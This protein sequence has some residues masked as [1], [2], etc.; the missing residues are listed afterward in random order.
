VLVSL[1]VA[2]VR[3]TLGPPCRRTLASSLVLSRPIPVLKYPL[4]RRPAYP[5]A[6][7]LADLSRRSPLIFGLALGAGCGVEQGGLGTA[8]STDTRPVEARPEAGAPAGSA[9]ALDGGQ[10][11]GSD[12]ALAAGDAALAPDAADARCPLDG[13][14]ALRIDAVVQWAG[15][16]FFDIVPIILPG[17]GDMSLT[18]LSDLRTQAGE[19]RATIRACGSEVPAFSASIGEHYGVDFADSV[20]ERVP[21]R[22]SVGVRQTCDL[23]GCAFASDVVT[24]QLGLTLAD[25]AP[26]PSPRD[27]LPDSTLRDDDGDGIP[28]IVLR[29]RGPSDVGG[30]SYTHPPTNYLLTSRVSEIS[31]AVRVSAELAGALDSC[32]AYGGKAYG[33]TV[34]T[35]ALACRLDDGTSCTPEQLGFVDDN[36]PV[37]KVDRATWTT[38]RVPAGA[39]CADARAALR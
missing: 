12:A 25:S 33:M 31:L 11:P 1:T 23:P 29:T 32:D 9:D 16:S 38:V 2:S 15:T 19:R 35:R 30:P 4:G 36:L 10:S 6:H 20:W 21:T 37:W 7:M 22:W 24:A 27:V 17:E 26:W 3:L 18:V 8:V 34:D 14:F 13:L 28:G 5:A 39:S